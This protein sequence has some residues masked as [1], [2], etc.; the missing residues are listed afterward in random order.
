[1]QPTPAAPDPNYGFAGC[2]RHPDRLTGVRCVRCGR[3]ICPQCQ[4]PAAVGFQC[5]DDVKAGR[6][7]V[8]RER[9]VLG[10]RAVGVP[11]VTYGLIG[12]NVLVYLL[13]ALDHGGSL[14]DNNRSTLFGQWV[15][16]PRMVGQHLEYYRLITSAFLHYGPIHILLNMYALYVIGPLLE[17]LLGRWRYLALYLLAALGGS[18]AVLTLDSIDVGSAGA[19]GAIFGLFA[20]AVVLGRRVGFNTTALWITIGINFI[21]TFSVPG[22]SK[23]GHVGGFVLGGLAALVLIGGQLS[24]LSRPMPA[25]RVQIVGLAALLGVLLVVAVGRTQQLHSQLTS[26]SAAGPARSQGSFIHSVDTPGENYTGV[27]TAVE[28]AVD[29]R[30][31]R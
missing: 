5:P 30:F 6:A 1:M 4:R 8:R 24:R 3:P 12:L 19:S 11:A 29:N 10:A 18:V 16:W 20:A 23:L 14:V 28:E 15:L 25:A 31:G 27:I 7:T 13:T 2:Y 21:F 9:T 26:G 17:Q 22:I